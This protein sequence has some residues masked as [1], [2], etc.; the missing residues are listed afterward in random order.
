MA[1]EVVEEV[2]LQRRSDT[3]S[4][5]L[6]ATAARAS[7]AEEASEVVPALAGMED[8]GMV[9]AGRKAGWDEELGSFGELT[10]RAG[11]DPCQGQTAEAARTVAALRLLHLRLLF[12]CRQQWPATGGRRLG[13]AL[14]YGF[15]VQMQAVNSGDQN[16][17]TQ[18]TSF[19]KRSG[20]SLRDFSCVSADST[21][22]R[23][24]DRTTTVVNAHFAMSPQN[25]LLKN[26][27]SYPV[28]V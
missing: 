18:S 9:A 14:D 22:D 28:K 1:A 24:Y 12:P 21:R 11:A 4:L 2:Q 17:L 7:E 26:K 6:V 20:I 19:F 15:A 27:R 5:V 23:M 8:S 3:Q 25:L 10:A 16:S 13:T